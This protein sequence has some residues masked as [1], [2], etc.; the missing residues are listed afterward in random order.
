MGH[1]VNA[2]DMYV[3]YRGYMREQQ[4]RI[5]GAARSGNMDEMDDA[6]RALKGH[7]ASVQKER[8][9]ICA[10]ASMPF[11]YRLKNEYRM[12]HGSR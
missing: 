3:I 1:T 5:V 2:I 7:A 9:I 4:R 8:R 12:S 10:L 6:A 11:A